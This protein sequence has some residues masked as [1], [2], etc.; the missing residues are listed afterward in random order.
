[1]LRVLASGV[2][3]SGRATRPASSMPGS[4]TLTMLTADHT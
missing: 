2:S 3:M 4:N 1:M